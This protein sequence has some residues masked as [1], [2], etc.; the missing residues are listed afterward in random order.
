[1]RV[2]VIGTGYVGLVTG[3]CLAYLGNRV[4]CVDMDLERIAKLSSGEVPIYE[5]HLE[6]ILAEAA[7][8]GGLDF[9]GD[10]A[11]PVAESEVI[12]ITVGTPASPGGAPDLRFVEAAARSIGR[13]MDLRRRP[14]IVNKST[15][16]VG[17]G[18]LVETLINE[19]HIEAGGQRTSR[20]SFSV[21]SN[22]EFLQ[23]GSAISNSLY[24]DRIVIGA[25]N[26]EAVAVMEQ[27]YRP[28]IEQ[29][30]A[31][32]SFLPRPADVTQVPFLKTSLTSAE[33]IKYAAN[34]FLALKISFANEVAQI[35][36]R[37]G[38]D[39]SDVMKG[40]GLDNRIGS[41]FL[42]AGVGWGGSCFGKD[43]QALTQTAL[44]YGYRP[45]ILEAAQEVN[46]R[47]R[48]AVIQKLQEKLR[49]L[50]GRTIGLLGLAFKPETDDLRDAPSLTIAS[51]LLELGARVKVY[52]PVAMSAC[53]QQNPGLKI[54]YCESATAVAHGS[55]ALVVVTEWNEFRSLDL[56][57]LRQQ[58]NRPVLI[59]GRNIFKAADARVAGFDYSGIG[60]NFRVDEMGHG[61]LFLK[62]TA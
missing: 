30:F 45:L 12:F 53:R 31:A 57:A 61:R 59:D 1:V 18:N 13:T 8:N 25:E 14:V 20:I 40:I 5:P 26:N 9:T 11:K 62:A 34:S 36:E 33:M 6:E 47:Q 27:L 7:R 51:R 4:T 28:I 15:V 48:Q 23:E 39:C 58:M 49:I 17:S 38:G 10:Y 29:S 24:P 21:V 19:G 52:D 55:D 2:T 56:H 3:A 32:P 22:P 41:K 16:P 42:N 35:C 54:Q 60:S 37:V 50:K 43:L 46:R 44:E